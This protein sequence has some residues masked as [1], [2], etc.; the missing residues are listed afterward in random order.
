MPALSAADF[1]AEALA[2]GRL[3]LVDFWAPWCGPCRMM[4]PQFEQAAAALEPH[5]RLAKL[6]T[7]ASQALA[8]RFAIRSIPTVAVFAGGR[9]VAR[10]SGAMD[11]P[12]LERWVRAAAPV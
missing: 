3:V 7:E 8:A 5:Y 1:D 2:P 12:T 4:A 6:D 10:Q 9:E 11:A